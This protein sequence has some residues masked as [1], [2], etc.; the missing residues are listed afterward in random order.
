VQTRQNLKETAFFFPHI[1]TD[2]NGNLSFNFTSPESLTQWKFRMMS[3]T[4]N[5]LS[6]YFESVVT[7]QKDLMIQPN[8]PR[9][10]RETDTIIIKAKVANL[11]AD[12]HNGM[13]MLQLFDP[14]TGE[15]IDKMTANQD[16]VKS[17]TTQP[18]TSETLS[19]TI[20]I[21]KGLQGL[22]YKI[23][24]KA[25]NFTDGE[26]SIIPVLSSRIFITESL[27]IWVRENSKKD[28]VF[29]NL[30]NNTS[31]TLENHSFT[32]E[33]CS[34]PTWIAIGSLPYLMEYEYEC[35]E[36]L[37]AKYFANI[38]AHKILD[39]TP[40]VKEVLERW[41][42]NPTSKLEQN[43]E[44]KNILLS[45]T[46]WVRQAQ[47]EEEQKKNLAILFDLQKMTT[48]SSEILDKL[49]ERQNNSG[50]FSWFEGGIESSFIT[51]HIT[52][53]FGHLKKLGISSADYD[54]I[55]QKMVA[56]LDTEFL[57]TTNTYFYNELHY[58]YARSFYPQISPSDSLE[59][60]IDRRIQ[61]FKE[62]WLTLSLYEKAMLALILQ[63]KTDTKT[64]KKILEHFKE[65]AVINTDFGMYWLENVNSPYWY[66]AP[67][68]TQALLIE[69]FS[70]IAPK[71]KAIEEMKVWLIKNKQTKSWNSTKST[72]L[73]VN[74][75]VSGKKDFI[76]LKDNTIFSIGNQKIKTQKLD[77]NSKE[78]ETGYFKMSWKANEITSDFA[79][80]SVDNKSKSVGFGGVYW[81]YFEE[82]DKV[83]NAGSDLMKIE[84]ELYLKKTTPKGNEL[85]KITEKTPLKLGDLVTIRLVFSVKEDIDFVHL[86][87]MRASGFEPVDVLSEYVYKEGLRFYK[88]TKDVATHFFF[89]SIKPGTYVLE[90]D[91]RVNNQ[92]SF[93]GGIT[94]IQS[95][96][97]PEYSSHTSSTRVIAGD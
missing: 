2:K 54:E 83:K 93:S 34:N 10:V 14:I 4:K 48:S 28:F 19:W 82:L 59:Q 5:L 13:A 20:Y 1:T 73:A 47:S 68:E 25:G 79:M 43:Q 22:E 89:D 18:K 57:R 50:G 53:G 44:L 16:N 85:V 17:F 81:S 56:Y 26:Q 24:A 8:M 91:V 7:T 38:L 92:G 23:T 3:H 58:L 6:G 36:Q 87:D 35:S 41:S 84:K 42:K 90:Y 9:F 31:E 39:D 63:R 70:E 21:P 61:Y 88:S 77:K 45:E 51:T 12:V 67:I 32:L 60:K 66:K 33:Y 71:D 80:V 37:F 15:N 46:P 69:A 96:Y 30:N 74:A 72:T 62:N 49:K 94:T 97:A 78:A 95:M 27:P 11:S 75:L 29:E 65:T 40:K 55:T 64:A 86:K 52:I 76:S